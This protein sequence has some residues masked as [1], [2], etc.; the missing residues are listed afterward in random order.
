MAVKLEDKTKHDDK[1][2]MKGEFKLVF[3]PEH[4]KHINQ[5]KNMLNGVNW[6]LALYALDQKI[7]QVVKYGD[8]NFSDEQKDALD[9]VREWIYELLDEHQ[10]SF[11]DYE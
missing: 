7:R 10:I 1:E 4:P 9:K 2:F 8:P 6:Y 5:L 11:D 3:D